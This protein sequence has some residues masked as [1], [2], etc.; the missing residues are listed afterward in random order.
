MRVAFFSQKP[1]ARVTKH[2]CN[3]LGTQISVFGTISNIYGDPASSY[4]IDGGAPTT[5]IATQPTSIQ[6]K[7]QFFQSPVLS[8]GAHSL[9]ITFN[10]QS[11]TAV[12]FLD[13]ID[14][15][16]VTNAGTSPSSASSSSSSL[17]SA[18]AAPQ[19]GPPATSLAAIPATDVITSTNVQTS[20]VIVS[21]T[22]PSPS[23]LSLNASASV[24]ATRSTTMT[25][26][27][28]MAT[29]M[30]QANSTQGM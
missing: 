10:S 9:L 12:F 25:T 16:P 7:Q 29:N 24:S 3:F 4:S 13:Y 18:A 1:W 30:N 19:S 23:A 22:P 5:F 14:I 11:N 20:L 15:T 28:M 21:S 6:Y 2:L 26:L 8:P 27:T 17:S